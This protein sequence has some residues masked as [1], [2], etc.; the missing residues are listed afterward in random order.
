MR[1]NTTNCFELN[2]QVLHVFTYIHNKTQIMTKGQEDIF[3]IENNMDDEQDGRNE[4]DKTE[5]NL[6]R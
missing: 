3:V 6:T 5:I 1:A 4:Y 2:I